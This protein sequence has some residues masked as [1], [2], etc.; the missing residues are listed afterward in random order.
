MKMNNNQLIPAGLNPDTDNSDNINPWKYQSS[1][2]MNLPL[3]LSKDDPLEV[4]NFPIRL[5][6]ALKNSGDITTVGKFCDT[7]K[8]KLLKI[9][10]IGQKSVNFMLGF[11]EAIDEKFGNLQNNKPGESVSKESTE[12]V[13]IL[14]DQ[15]IAQLFDKCGNDKAKD[16]I[17]RR[18]GLVNGERQ[19]L[20]EIGE[21]Y[22]VTRERIRQIQVKALKRMRHPTSL[23]VKPLINLI[24]VVIF[25]NGGLLSA[26][27]A[28]R[29]IP[30][31][32]GGISED[33]SS[34]LDLVC[35][36]RGIQSCKIGD[37]P[38]YS[39]LLNGVSLCKLSEKIIVLI[40]KESLGID[41][42]SIVRQIKLFGKITDERF[43]P[44]DFV[45]KYCKTDPRIE[46]IGLASAEVEVI[47]RHYTSGFAKKGWVDLMVRVLEEEQMPLHFTEITNK[48]NDLMSNTRR[49]LDV[50]RAHS[51]LIESEAFAHSG[52]HGTYGLTSWGLRKDT[53]PELVEECLRKA[54]FP[55]HWKQIYNYVSKYKDSKQ[56]SITSVL[57]TN[58]MFKKI[59]SGIYGLRD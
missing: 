56:E 34:V 13:E 3:S 27:E 47:F 16:I 15:L 24:E 48:V 44:Q 21:H 39:P 7:P 40:K 12:E 38:I 57:E 20:E 1:D 5:E 28:D 31:A 2:D 8:E 14:A 41:V 11:K 9:R 6:N 10:N 37:I 33:G 23:A 36:L 19:T 26:E 42:S 53:T 43:N 35:D 51:V 58:R 25:Q 55:L 52:I 46:E 59:E 4:L 22:K 29:I 54:G 50:R 18:Y 45:L 30:K 49:Q 32:L 17:K